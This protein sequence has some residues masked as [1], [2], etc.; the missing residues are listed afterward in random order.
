M[1]YFFVDLPLGRYIES[2]SDGSDVLPITAIDYKSNAWWDADK[3]G[4]VIPDE[5]LRAY[6]ALYDAQSREIAQ[7][8]IGEFAWCVGSRAVIDTPLYDPAWRVKTDGELS[9]VQVIAPWMPCVSTWLV[10]RSGDAWRVVP[11]DDARDYLQSRAR[12]AGFW[13]SDVS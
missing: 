7:L 10:E 1:N 4:I 8:L 3:P 11:S 5:G 12:R 2:L 13:R 9:V 6:W